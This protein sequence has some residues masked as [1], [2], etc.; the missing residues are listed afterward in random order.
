MSNVQKVRIAYVGEALNSGVMDVNDLAPALLAFGNLVKRV[1]IV[2]G[3]EHPVRIL[4]KADDIRKGSFDITL[5]LDYNILEEAKL[6]MGFADETGLKALMDVLGMS[7][8][9]KESIFWLIK[10]IGYKRIKQAEKQK[11]NVTIV[12]EDNTAI[13]VNQNVYNVFLDYETRNF[14]EK[15]VAPVKKEGIAGFEIRN[16][17]DLHDVNPT[18]SIDKTVVDCFVTPA[19]ETKVEDDIV[20]E[21]EMMVKIVSIVFDEKQK[22]RFSDG[23]AVFWAKITDDKFWQS[24]DEGTIA[25]RKGDRLKVLCKVLQRTGEADSLITERTITKV[26]KIIPKPTQ[27]KLNF[28]R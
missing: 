5:L 14:I 28:E 9:A 11:D 10:V 6:F 21:Q 2:I 17:E 4:L 3:N 15:V 8:T 1:N 24:I 25:F 19:L 16:P 27:I 18:V 13:T 23:E 12:L 20:F 7:I 26:I 22:W